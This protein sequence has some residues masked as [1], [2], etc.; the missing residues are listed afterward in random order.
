MC[1]QLDYD[2]IRAEAIRDRA[3]VIPEVRGCGFEQCDS[4]DDSLGGV[5]LLHG[6]LRIVRREIE[7]ATGEAPHHRVRFW[8]R[9]RGTLHLRNRGRERSNKKKKK[10]RKKKPPLVPFPPTVCTVPLFKTVARIYI[11]ISCIDGGGKMKNKGAVGKK[12][13]KKVGNTVSRSSYSYSCTD[14]FIEN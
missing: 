13:R 6:K 5:F 12:K 3:V 8:H 10:E 2:G 14:S 7:L 1:R 11:H 9:Y 4:A